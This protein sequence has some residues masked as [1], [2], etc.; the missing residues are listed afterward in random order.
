[1]QQLLHTQKCFPIVVKS[2]GVRL[3]LQLKM[4]AEKKKLIFKRQK[5]IFQK[6]NSYSPEEQ[7][8]PGNIYHCKCW[9]KKYA[10]FF[11]RKIKL[12]FT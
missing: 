7:C 12:L 10:G 1:M 6:N 2:T 5:L 4:L 3:Y 9:Q 11:L 8:A